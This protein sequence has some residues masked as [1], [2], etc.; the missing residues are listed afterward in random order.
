MMI[1]EITNAL[2][3]DALS[4]IYRD[5]VNAIGKEER[6]MFTAFKERAMPTFERLVSG[7]YKIN[8]DDSKSYYSQWT[9]DAQTGE[10]YFLRYGTHNTE[11]CGKQTF[12]YLYTSSG[13]QSHIKIHNQNIE[14]WACVTRNS[15]NHDAWCNGEFANL[16]VSS[17]MFRSML[18]MLVLAIQHFNLDI[19]PREV[20][21]K[22]EYRG[23][24]HVLG[25]LATV[26][27]M[28]MR[29]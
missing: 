23:S 6:L 24:S 25:T 8:T 19:D 4:H 29:A 12:L 20:P 18:P 28:V 17:P 15:D 14:L 7:E 9:P 27:R 13:I 5:A 11:W 21:F 26:V 16:Q 2:P 3:N 22:Y 10:K 1:E